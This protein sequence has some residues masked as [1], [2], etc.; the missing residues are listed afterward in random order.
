VVVLVALVSARQADVVYQEPHLALDYSDDIHPYA[1]AAMRPDPYYDAPLTA[2]TLDEKSLESFLDVQT[3]LKAKNAPPTLLEVKEDLSISTSRK[4]FGGKLL[5]GAAGLV[6]GVAG[7]AAG[8]VMGGKKKGPSGGGFTDLQLNQK[9]FGT[10]TD[11]KPESNPASIALLPKGPP[12]YN[13]FKRIPS[14]DKATGSFPGHLHYRRAQWGYR[15]RRLPYYSKREGFGSAN[16]YRQSNHFFH[17]PN[18]FGNPRSPEISKWS[19]ARDPHVFDLGPVAHGETKLPYGGYSSFH[20]ARFRASRHSENGDAPPSFPPVPD[21]RFS[22]SFGPKGTSSVPRL[23]DGS[24]RFP[25]GHHDKLPVNYPTFSPA[26]HPHFGAVSPY[27][28]GMTGDYFNFFGG[29][30]G[31]DAG[32]GSA[33]L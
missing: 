4:G 10:V 16:P 24:P 1:W 29:G 11:K 8:M 33:A 30:G 31:E 23:S 26:A 32:E 14:G 13:D 3:S 22:S 9:G 5:R 12:I 7:A 20:G 28:V 21:F 2:Y 25:P 6:G 19:A 18:D 17:S 15:R 27:V